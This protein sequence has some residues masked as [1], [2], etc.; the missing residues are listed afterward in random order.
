MLI[1]KIVARRH[2]FAPL[3]LGSFRAVVAPALLRLMMP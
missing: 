3:S 1:D 2:V